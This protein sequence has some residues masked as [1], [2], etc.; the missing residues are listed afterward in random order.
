MEETVLYH[1]HPA[2]FKNRPWSFI[3]CLILSLVGIGLII[4][5]IWWIRTKGTELTVTDERV[6]LRKGILS[7]FT[8]DVYLTD[9][10]NVQIYQSFWQRVFGVGSVAIS[11]A[12]HEGIEIDIKG[13]PAPE[14]IKAIIDTHRRD[15]G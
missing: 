3:L 10:R 8:N 11:S 5:L 14:K 6:S 12:G 15:R 2:M 7:K 1:S 13:I 9:I 4:L